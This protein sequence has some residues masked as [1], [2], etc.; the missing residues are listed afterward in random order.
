MMA[1]G[2]GFGEAWRDSILRRLGQ[3]HD[4]ACIR[5]AFGGTEGLMVGLETPFSIFVRRLAERSPDIAR[6]LF[7]E[8]PCYS[9]VQYSPMGNYIE[10]VDGEMIMTSGGAVPLVRYN[11]HDRGGL[12]PLARTR[13]VL[14]QAGVGDR[15]L[16]AAGVN[17]NR[18][19]K[20][21]LL[22]CHGRRDSVSVDGV[23]IFVEA[24]APVFAR[25]NVNGIS[26]WKLSLVERDDGR[27]NWLVLVELTVPGDEMTEAEGELAHA[28]RDGVVDELLR[29][30][31]DFRS[32]Y[33]QQPHQHGARSEGIRTLC[34]SIRG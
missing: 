22:Y 5:G 27:I 13:E 11:L 30:S 14:Q 31:S 34:R 18:I 23:A 17:P 16:E 15:E 19:W 7:G 4:P 12:V 20:M 24:V 28:V 21:P 2:D 25:V 8:E 6:E 3:E 1:G 9:M 26:N 10:I 29:S 32:A 33:H